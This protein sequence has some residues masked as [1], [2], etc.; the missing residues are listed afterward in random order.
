MLGI[1]AHLVLSQPQTSTTE[2]Q[3][4]S[5]Q[6]AYKS[7]LVALHRAK[8]QGICSACELA[9][10]ECLVADLEA[11]LRQLEPQRGTP[12]QGL[13]GPHASDPLGLSWQ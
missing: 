13:Q 7:A 2:I 4:C 8:A 9:I 12:V 5:I 6:T 3:Y 1:L 10:L 11:A